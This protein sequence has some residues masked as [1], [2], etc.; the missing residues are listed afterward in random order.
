M[1]TLVNTAKCNMVDLIASGMF[2]RCYIYLF[3]DPITPGDPLTKHSPDAAIGATVQFTPDWVWNDDNDFVSVTQNLTGTST[4][5][6]TAVRFLMVGMDYSGTVAKYVI[7]GT[8]GPIGSGADLEITPDSF[9][10]A[11]ETF[12]IGTLTIQPPI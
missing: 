8:V 6:G 4:A 7:E 3:G 11:G 12:T 10:A 2:W 9:T 1:I 5:A